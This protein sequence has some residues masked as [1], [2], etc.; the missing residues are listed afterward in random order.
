[1]LRLNP[2]LGCEPQAA[3]LLLAEGAQPFRNLSSRAG[4]DDLPIRL[5]EQLDTLPVIR[6][7]AGARAGCLEHPCGWR[8]PIS[9]HTFAIDIEHGRGSAVEGIMVPGVHMA[10]IANIGRHSL[11]SP[12]AS[13]EEES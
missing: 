6:H 12:P 2:S 4:D 3:A 9:R 10:D 1:M 11:V 7:E 5:E 8:E 13:T